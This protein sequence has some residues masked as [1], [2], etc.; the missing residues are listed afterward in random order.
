MV[1]TNRSD[2]W[3]SMWA[4]KDHG[5]TMAVFRR[6]HESGFRWLHERFGSNFRLTELQS[7][8]GCI[9]LK[10]LP[11]GLLFALAMLSCLRNN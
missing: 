2:F 5:K 3:E 9:Q 10:S 1:I 4:F 6:N 8:I 7:S 11:S